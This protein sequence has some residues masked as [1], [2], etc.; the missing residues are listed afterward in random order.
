M[1]SN[2]KKLFSKVNCILVY[3]IFNIEYIPSVF[4]YSFQFIFE[5]SN[6]NSVI[7]IVVVNAIKGI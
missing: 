3:L 5:S 6:S 7:M 2:G 1:H 4:L